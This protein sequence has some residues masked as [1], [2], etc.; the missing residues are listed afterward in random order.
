MNGRYRPLIFTLE[1][2]ML[3]YSHGLP[4]CKE[5]L[6][7]AYLALRHQSAKDHLEQLFLS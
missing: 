1:I 6:H 4:N 7:P 3:K 2:S 5:P